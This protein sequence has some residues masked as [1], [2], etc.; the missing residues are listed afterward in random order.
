MGGQR[1]ECEIPRAAVE[2]GEDNFFRE[3][4]CPAPLAICQSPFN[5][6]AKV[7]VEKI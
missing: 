5:Y 2:G 1:S 3:R 4:E 7:G 6:G